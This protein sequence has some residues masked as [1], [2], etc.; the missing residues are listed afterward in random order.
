MK[1]YNTAPIGTRIKLELANATGNTNLD[2]LTANTGEWET[3]VWNF[4]GKANDYDRLQ[5][6]FDFGNVGDG[7]DNSIFLFDDVQQITGPELAAPSA[8][9]L[10]INFEASVVTTDFINVGG[11]VGSIIS[12]P[13]II[14]KNTSAT[15]GQFVRSGGASWAQ[16]KLALTGFISNMN[17]G[18]FLSMNV[19]SDAPLGTLLKFKLESNEAGFA[20]ERDAYT[21]VSGEWK[22][23][24]WNFTNGDSPIYNV[25]TLMLGYTIPNDASANAT[26]LFDDIV[27][28][29]TTLS[30]GNDENFK[31][32]GI[33]SYPNPAKDRLTIISE[34]KTIQRISLFDILGHQVATLNPNSLQAT[35]DVADFAAGIYIAKIATSKETGSIKFI[36]E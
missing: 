27:Q 25:I 20:V 23:Y 35:I 19:Y 34:N 26:F 30:S 28:G 13:N 12:N 1:V 17:T 29:S 22:T 5:F 15:V 11:G 14:E 3:A 33:I 21:T 4:N 16:T 7:L 8:T 36:I 18:G 6:M 32:N 31:I 9:S 24:S 2:Y 10:P